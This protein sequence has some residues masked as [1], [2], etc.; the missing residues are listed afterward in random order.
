MKKLSQAFN[1]LITIG[2]IYILATKAPIFLAHFKSEGTEAPA[3]SVLMNSGSEFNSE[4][5]TAKK[6]LVF[7]ATWCPPCELELSRIND[8]V[9]EK[10]IPA[11]SILAI[12]MNE[13]KALV[14]RTVQERGYQF[15]VAYDFNGS[16]GQ[17][18]NVIGTPTVVFV[19]ADKSINWMTTGISPLLKIRLNIFLD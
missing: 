7:W 6:V 16:V 2:I 15:P 9:K 14:D 11:D 8:L 19:N 17:K 18:F 3:F 1:I 13:E 5:L 12:S 10:R 4:N